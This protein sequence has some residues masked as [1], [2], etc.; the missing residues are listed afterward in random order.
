MSGIKPVLTYLDHRSHRVLIIPIFSW[1]EH[2]ASVWKDS[3][4][5][6]SA[7]NPVNS[8]GYD[9]WSS[10]FR[11][12]SRGNWHV[13]RKRP[14]SHAICQGNCQSMWGCLNQDQDWCRSS[15][16]L[17]KETALVSGLKFHSSS[18]LFNPFNSP[19]TWEIL[20]PNSSSSR[21]Q[22]NLQQPFSGQ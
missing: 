9:A 12:R 18:L 7:P 19:W 5:R 2:L 1:T 14:K 20:L 22:K 15:M 8:E 11:W 6:Y 21:L 4:D 10:R 17:D 16:H 3:Y 13:G